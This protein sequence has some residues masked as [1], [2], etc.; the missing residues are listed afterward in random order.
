MF[1]LS[2]LDTQWNN[3]ITHDSRKNGEPWPT[4]YRQ[5][6]RYR[7][8]QPSSSSRILLRILPSRPGNQILERQLVVQNGASWILLSHAY[9]ATAESATNLFWPFPRTA[10][11]F[12]SLISYPCSIK[13]F[14]NS[15]KAFGFSNNATSIPAQITER[16]VSFLR[17]GSRF[18]LSL[19]F[20]GSITDRPFSRQIISLS[21]CK[22]NA[23]NQ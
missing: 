5:S 18:A 13:S 7:C 1:Q 20:L 16:K 8:P 3:P 10:G 4:H 12:P 6:P 14:R 22:A 9:R 19:G 17:Y 23:I 11:F 2:Q 15:S 21:F